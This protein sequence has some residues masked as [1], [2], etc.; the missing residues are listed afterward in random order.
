VLC[1]LPC[2]MIELLLA[3]LTAVRTGLLHI[4]YH[5]PCLQG[6]CMMA[7]P[8]AQKPSNKL[9]LP[10][11]L[12]SPNQP[13]RLAVPW[14][15]VVMHSRWASN[16]H[17]FTWCMRLGKNKFTRLCFPSDFKSLVSEGGVRSG[18]RIAQRLH[19]TAPYWPTHAHLVPWQIHPG[20]AG[21]S[22]LVGIG[23]GRPDV[24]VARHHLAQ[25]PL[26]PVVGL[27]NANGDPILPNF[28]VTILVRLTGEE[29][30]GESKLPQYVD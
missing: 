7:R 30:G 12:V 14:S 22:Q 19:C 3:L 11:L 27:S 5:H 1:R 9:Q 25:R 23:A 15:T 10:Q 28:D 29:G 13:V 21:G 24:G 6:L 17:L 20:L 18:A 8:L 26:S 2:I 4:A 16:N